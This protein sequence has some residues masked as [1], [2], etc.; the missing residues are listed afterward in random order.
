MQ[1]LPS[2]ERTRPAGRTRSGCDRHQTDS[3]ADSQEHFEP[4]QRHRSEV[5]DL[6]SGMIRRKNAFRHYCPPQRETDHPSSDRRQK[7]YDRQCR[8]RSL[9]AAKQIIDARVIAQGS[10]SARRRRFDRVHSQRKLTSWARL[11]IS[12]AIRCRRIE[13]WI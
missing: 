8:N 11:L 2:R 12:I 1:K 6:S 9:R 10:D 4:I 13:T 3:R 5:H 7:H